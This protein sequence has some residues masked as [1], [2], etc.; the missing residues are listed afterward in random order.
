VNN[1]KEISQKDLAE[2]IRL[3]QSIEVMGK[4]L[5]DLEARTM[6]ALE[7]GAGVEPGMLRAAIKMFE[8]RNV[9]WKDVVL[10]ECGEAFVT[11]VLAATKPDQYSKLE[12]GL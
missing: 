1:Q 7:A 8:R 3:R 2:V 6:A 11:R 4:T 5:K 9:S 12:V 10:R